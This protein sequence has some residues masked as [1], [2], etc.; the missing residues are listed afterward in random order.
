ME[1]EKRIL[2]I[3]DSPIFIQNIKF[4]L[5]TNFKEKYDFKFYVKNE[6][7][8]SINA[9]ERFSADNINIDIVILNVDINYKNYDGLV[10]IKKFVNRI[11]FYFPEVKIIISTNR[12]ENYRINQIIVNTSPLGFIIENKTSQNELHKLFISIF[13]YEVYYPKKIYNIMEYYR[14]DFFKIDEIE[15]QILFLLK[16]GIKTNFLQYYIP[17]SNSTIEKVKSSLK[18]RLTL[19]NRSDEQLVKEAIKRGFLNKFKYCKN[20]SY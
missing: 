5:R 4:L 3:D 14:F 1:L 7:L 6:Y 16:S 12:N 9:L 8:K 2:F 10:L 13:N 18:D 20:Y 15:F 11:K 17:R 19:K